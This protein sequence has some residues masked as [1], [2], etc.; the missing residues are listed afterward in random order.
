MVNAV[1]A[2]PSVG[3]H[4][5]PRSYTIPHAG[6]W[7]D[8]PKSPESGNPV[9]CDLQPLSHSVSAAKLPSLKL[10]CKLR[11]ASKKWPDVEKDGV[12]GAEGYRRVRTEC[13]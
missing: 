5:L 7:G 10:L 13:P 12:M 3:R 8:A 4:L 1:H 2:V 6:G 11:Y 9:P